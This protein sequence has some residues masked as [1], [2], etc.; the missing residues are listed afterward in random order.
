MSARRVRTAAVVPLCVIYTKN[1]RDDITSR[2]QHNQCNKPRTTAVMRGEQRVLTAQRQFVNNSSNGGTTQ[3]VS[4]QALRE[5]N[6][7]KCAQQ[8]PTTG[9]ITTLRQQLQLTQQNDPGQKH[10]QTRTCVNTR[11]MQASSK[12]DR[13]YSMQISSKEHKTRTNKTSQ[14]QM[15]K[16]TLKEPKRRSGRPHG[17]I[18]RQ[19]QK[20]QTPL[21]S[22]QITA[23]TSRNETTQRNEVDQCS[24]FAR[25][26]ELNPPKHTHDSSRQKQHHIDYETHS[27]KQHPTLWFV[28]IHRH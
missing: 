6:T 28:I 17:T 3:T 21:T 12:D 10:D 18:A 9:A 11:R 15:K 24:K 8:K 2:Q 25:K 4:D 23:K 7:M 22:Q 14:Y 26:K 27:T 1:N 5:T 20:T 13:T 19:Q 16:P